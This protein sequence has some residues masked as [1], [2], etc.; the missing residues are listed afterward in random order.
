MKSWILLA[1]I[2]TAMLSLAPVGSW[3]GETKI[4]LRDYL[5]RQWTN[6]L[7]T[8]PFSAARGACDA[9]SVSLTGP[10]GAV[11]VQLT[12]IVYWPK[13]RWVKSARLCFVASLAPL[14]TDTYILRYGN[15]PVAPLATDL[16][17]T[18][19]KDR[20][21]I[22]TK[23]FGARL[24]LGEKTF[25]TSIVA[26][27]APDPVI[28]MRL[29][30]GTWFGGS[31]MYGPGKLKAYSAKLTDSGPVFARVA[32]RYTYENGNTLD[33]A[34]RLAAGDNTL[35]CETNVK[36]DQPAD[37]FTLVLNRGL[38]PFVFQVQDESRNDRPCFPSKNP[39]G[40]EEI[41]LKEYTV[42]DNTAIWPPVTDARYALVTALSPWED[43]FG[44]YTQT[45]IRLK[46]ENTGRELQV[47][48]LDPGAW[49]EPREIEEIFSPKLDWDPQKGIWATWQ[50]KML[51]LQR[52]PNGEVF[53]QV[54]AAQGVRKWT[55]SDC[56]SVPGMA[57]MYRYPVY[58]PESDFPSEARP[59]IGTR[60]DEVKDYI[61][62]WRGDA[63]TH[64]RLF[65][66]RSE[67]EARW[68]R[69]DADP[70]LVQ[71]LT[72]YG[73]AGSEESVTNRRAILGGN[74]S[75]LGAYLL[76]GG[77]PTVAKETQLAARL[78]QGLQYD[79]WGVQFG[80]AGNPTTILYDGLID[81]PVIPEAERTLLR[82]R[83]AYYVYRLADPAVWSAERGY[84]SGNQNMT[85][86]WEISR[87]IAA[88]AIPTHPMAKTWYRKAERIMDYFLEH[89]VGPAG[90]WPE[91][92]GDHGRHSMDMLLAFAVASTNSGLHDYVN[93]PRMKR[94][95]LYWAK[96]ETPRD[97][98]PRGNVGGPN[99]R[100]FPAMG[101]DRI[102][103]PGG[104]CGVMA[105]MLTR[106]DPAL[107]AEL[108]W[109]WL[110]EGGEGHLTHLGGFAY[111]ACDKTLPARQPAWTSEVLPYNGAIFRHGL[112]TM[113]EHQVALYSGDHFAAFYPGH[114]GSFPNIFAFG[115]PVAG[116]WPGCYQDQ[117]ELL[118][119]NVMLARGLG[120]ME[121]RNLSGYT[122]IAENVNMWSWPDDQ[123][124]RFG[125]HGGLSNVSS[126]STLPR[127]DYA[128]VDVALHYPRTQRL[129]WRP[130]LPEWPPTPAKGTPPVDW[131]RQTL[132]LKDDDPANT[133]YL[134]IRDSV[135]GG[136]P[137]LWQ[138]WNVS[139]MLD[140]PANVKDVAAVLANKPGYKILPARELKGDR[141]T[142]LGQLGVDVEYYIA[143]PSDTPRHTLRWGTEFVFQNSNKLQQ[144]EYQDL[145][146]LQL[147]GDGTYFVAFFPRKR[148]TPA[149][150]FSRLG[151][152]TIIK[153]EGDFGKDYGFLSALDATASGEGASFTGTAA[154]VQ[155]RATGLVL[156]LGAKG[157]VRYNS[158]GLAADFPA[159]LRVQEKALTVELPVGIQPPAF[160]VMQP[161]P[162]GTVTVTA[163][164]DW[165]LAKP[166]KGVKLAKTTAGWALTVPAGV[167]AV[168]LVT[169]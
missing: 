163:P 153:V 28:A 89:M 90:E 156:S 36:D 132:F 166:L 143:S 11:P 32:V 152:G 4:V 33:M 124:A 6:E 1:A 24:L 78:R 148:N 165:S 134:L 18:P 56:L 83:M 41:P 40:W 136:Q 144:P 155:D 63:G 147:P 5:N 35:R 113:N 52:D 118:L 122:G 110:E 158:Y 80:I 151:D 85:V 44:T 168:K 133:A 8:Y 46:L 116:A 74:D 75:A 123:L 42:P 10:R 21:E 131:R 25:P 29:A 34:L 76:S 125:E 62:E 51:P 104:T 47:R 117:E 31:Q 71:R 138:M 73:R 99:R 150:A 95:I 77:S 59:A 60:L 114:A 120:T 17:V 49:V 70:K 72:S 84:C 102:G 61:L 96:M 12:E 97:P 100:Y 101:R 115:V 161:F 93:D 27:E 81:S 3:A 169:Q 57:S 67:L 139:E 162:G 58:Q 142:V 86:V 15:K 19:G 37:G 127:Q 92:N 94:L 91:A 66:S 160:Q 140:T 54:N 137:T 38:P 105:R 109:A 154:S 39:N 82:A 43:W 126:F 22:T 50:H 107:A 108:Q 167:R 164:G 87:G 14:V 23:G 98:R 111:V 129:P 9:R 68:K 79:L 2:I 112:G 64:P 45:R 48:S 159:G 106:H 7:L 55:I 119:C 128:A 65:I 53:L 103:S 69:K 157:E 130:T 121:E 88:C 20:V 141:F 135:R 146:H 16:T 26:A 145:L 13:T 30:D 149:P